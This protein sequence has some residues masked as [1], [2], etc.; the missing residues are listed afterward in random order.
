MQTCIQFDE[1]QT[2]EDAELQVDPMKDQTWIIEPKGLTYGDPIPTVDPADFD[3]TEFI[4][5]NTCS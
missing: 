3:T 2:I 1:D 4:I 5:R